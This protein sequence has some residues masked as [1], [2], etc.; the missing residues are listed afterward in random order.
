MTPEEITALV[1]KLLE[2]VSATLIKDVQ[3]FMKD[4]VKPLEDRLA[5]LE[6]PKEEAPAPTGDDPLS[7]R[8]QDLE[9]QLADQ[10][11]EKEA[12]D[13]AIA[14][15]QFKDALGKAVDV[16]NPKYR[17]EVLDILINRLQDGAVNKDGQWL[18]KEGKTLDEATA[19]FFTSDFGKHHLQPSHR[20]GADTPTP[21]NHKG[22]ETGLSLSDFST[23]L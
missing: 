21:K 23:L 16:H 20:E 6:A 13:K 18:T 5:G 2:P 4:T 8:L 11:A 12:Q 14:A 19:S 10:R 3:D 9:K 15:S 17:S 7:K 22:T 1:E